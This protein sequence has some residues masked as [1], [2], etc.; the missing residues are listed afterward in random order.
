MDLSK[1]FPGGVHKAATRFHLYFVKLFGC[2]IVEH[3]VP[4]DIAPFAFALRNGTPHAHVYLAF[5]RTLGKRNSKFAGSTP[6]ETTKIGPDVVYANWLYIVGDVFVDIIYSEN[7][8]YL[9]VVD[10][11][12]HPSKTGKIVRLSKLRNVRP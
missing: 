1:V 2:H 9:A 11:P 5:G 7:L 3:K 12:W 6:I 8:D 10:S 4:V